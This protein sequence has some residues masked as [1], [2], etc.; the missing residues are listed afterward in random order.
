MHW[1]IAVGAAADRAFGGKDADRLVL[2]SDLGIKGLGELGNAGTNAAVASAVYHATGARIRELPIR[3][4]KLLNA[5]S[6][7]L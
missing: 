2:T 1:L 6:I 7:A 5:P 4:E 3:P